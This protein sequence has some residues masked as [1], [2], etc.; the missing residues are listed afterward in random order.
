MKRGMGEWFDGYAGEPV[1]F[2]DDFY[3]ITTVHADF[4]LG[5]LDKYYCRMQVKGDSC[6]AEWKHVIITCNIDPQSWFKVNGQLQ[7]PF[8]KYKAVLNRIHRFTMF[9]GDSHRQEEANIPIPY[10]YESDSDS[11]EGEIDYCPAAPPSFQERRQEEEEIEEDPAILHAR[12]FSARWIETSSESSRDDND[13]N[14]IMFE[15]SRDRRE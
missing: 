6:L 9:E 14:H 11:Q 2:L 7:I 1:L 3:P 15:W 8:E 10:V 5:V 12:E 13:I 4:L